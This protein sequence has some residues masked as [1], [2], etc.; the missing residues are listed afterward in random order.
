MKIFNN[1]YS[2]VRNHIVLRIKKDAPGNKALIQERGELRKKEEVFLSMVGY[3]LFMKFTYTDLVNARNPNINNPVHAYLR[4]KYRDYMHLITENVIDLACLYAQRYFTP[5]QI[6]LVESEILEH[7]HK[8]ELILRNPH[9]FD[10]FPGQPFPR[11]TLY[12]PREFQNAFLWQYKTP[13]PVDGYRT[14]CTVGEGHFAQLG[15]SDWQKPAIILLHAHGKDGI[16]ENA[17]LEAEKIDKEQKLLMQTIIHNLRTIE[18]PVLG[19]LDEA[20]RENAHWRERYTKLKNK[21]DIMRD[22]DLD[23]L[24]ESLMS[25]Q[26]A[27]APKKKTN[28]GLVVLYGAVF[29]G[30]IVVISMIVSTGLSGGATNSTLPP[31]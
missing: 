6:Q 3:D 26:A 30:L 14:P 11:A 21:A 4:R 2:R 19:R 10:N 20:E 12:T 18:E 7:Y 17:I 16:L 8:S 22:E 27:N 5:E 25:R 9:E 23:A 28:W 1:L 31:P 13:W 24:E 15:W 29:I